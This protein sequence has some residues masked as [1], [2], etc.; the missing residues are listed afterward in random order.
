MIAVL[1]GD[2]VNSREKETSKWMPVLQAELNRIGKNPVDWEIYRGD[3]FQLKTDVNL[4]L[5]ILI[6]LKAAIKQFKKLDVRIAI[7]IGEE[8]YVAEK[9]T[10]SNGMAYVYS[11]KCFDGLKKQTMAIQSPWKDFDE[12]LNLLL[13]VLGLT[14]NNWTPNYANLVKASLENPNK[15]QAEI[16]LKLNK[17]QG[18]LS[19]ALKRAGF[20]EIE[21]I[22][23]FYTKKIE[24]LC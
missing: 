17:K 4:A 2:I 20:D 5:S 10:E 18:N 23:K 1:T 9:V 21:K 11:G 19:T 13:E 24:K 15:T 14:I 3:S 8:G 6:H 22:L 7:G 16:A 12:I